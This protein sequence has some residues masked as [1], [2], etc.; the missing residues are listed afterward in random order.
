LCDSEINVK[1]IAG[2]KFENDKQFLLRV[3]RAA[4]LLAAGIATLINRMER[5]LVTVGIDGSVYRFHPKFPQL[6]DDKIAELIDENLRYKL[7]LSEDGTGIG[8]AVVAA[9]RARI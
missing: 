2:I 7:M 5:P 4:H 3:F 6:L 1:K 9:W 8:A